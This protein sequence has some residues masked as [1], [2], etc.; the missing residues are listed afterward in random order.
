MPT[1]TEAIA[2]TW[3]VSCRGAHPKYWLPATDVQRWEFTLGPALNDSGNTGSSVVYLS[4][5][6]LEVQVVDNSEQTEPRLYLM[7]A[8]VSFP[9]HLTVQSIDILTACRTICSNLPQLD[10]ETFPENLRSKCQSLWP[11]YQESRGR[12]DNYRDVAQAVVDAAIAAPP[13]AWMTSGHPVIFDSVS[14]ILLESGRARGWIVQVV[15]AVSCIDTILAEVE[16]D[17]ADGLV[18]YEA[19]GLVMRRLPL[20]PSFATMLLQP[21]AFNSD[22]SHYS[23]EW[24]PN[25][26]PLRDYLLQFYRPE[27]KCAFVRSYSVHGGPARI[28]WIELA[29]MASA[30]FDAV[31]GSTLFVPSAV[32]EPSPG[33]R[34]EDLPLA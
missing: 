16:Y 15:P 29:S 11:L 32:S 19:T 2:T 21:S 7:G 12:A 3:S 9:E 6:R 34:G 28:T 30:P 23:T 5:I 13:V 25:L 10:L 26:A 1:T 24:S 20:V 22:I 18:V 4:T 33:R 17:P 27:H 8:G 31:A 14:K